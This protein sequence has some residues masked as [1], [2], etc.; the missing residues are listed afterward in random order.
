MIGIAREVASILNKKIKLPE[1]SFTEQADSIEKM[2]SVVIEDPDLCP[3]YA[4]RV[5]RDLEIQ[6]SPLWI[7]KRLRALGLRPIN[8]IVDITN[9]VLIERGHPLHAFDYDLLQEN[10]IVVRRAKDH[11]EIVTLDD[12]ERKL[13]REMLIIADAGRPVAIAGVMGGL[14][15]L[16]SEGTKNVLLESAYFD[17][18]SIRRTAKRL[19]LHT[20]ASHRFER[21]ADPEGVVLA[22]ERAAYLFHEIGKGK[23]TRGVIDAY[24]KRIE[25]PEIVLR[26]ERV[27]SVLGTDLQRKQIVDYLQRLGIK[28]SGTERDVFT[29]EVPSFRRDLTREIDLIEEVAR[30]HG[31][32]NIKT[33]LPQARLSFREKD[34]CQ[35]AEKRVKEIL[36]NCG[37]FEVV[38]YS[39]INE[40]DLD[41]LGL[42]SKD[43]ARQ[44]MRL[45]NP[46]SQEAGI[47]RTTLLPG[48]LRNVALNNNRNIHDVKIFEVGRA[49]LAKKGGSELPD[50][51]RYVSGVISGAREGNFW[52]SDKEKCDFFDMKGVVEV[53]F[54]GM[55]A[56]ESTS[57]PADIPYLYPTRSMDVEI[58]G[59]KIGVFGQ[60]KPDVLEAFDIQEE[61]T[62]AFE[63]ELEKLL[64]SAGKQKE[65]VPL[66][67]HPSVLRDIAI[68]VDTG[69][70]SDDVF[71]IIRETD[72]SILQ[73]V[74][75]FDVY[76]G[77]PIP[78]GKK[79][80]AYSL[81]Y[82]THDRTLTD[83]EVDVIHATIIQRLK[84][85]INASL[86]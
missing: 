49:F 19:K 73:D 43:R 48:L 44:F 80:L 82:R 12:V 10:R 23:I 61:N 4:A 46:I 78:E 29:A 39:F 13:D 24:P 54:S 68:V 42:S 16:V 55:N 59:E 8:N 17:P 37:F 22:S 75:L 26:T 7:Q 62:F 70:S 9:Y 60:I 20:E 81:I 51:E 53:L 63:I 72:Q 74:R 67:K 34:P 36:K 79:S 27:N 28:V 25:N 64:L 45:R 18:I 6:P 76:Q 58:K 15:T 52:Y 71:K 14:N 5:I 57:R 65:F 31:Y 30:L 40:S 85:K 11:E 83:G 38:N 3:R 77:K 1:C 86:R 84:D 69:V 50:E 21:G 32:D 2:T 56:T 41:S 35:N 47:M 33:T 66:P